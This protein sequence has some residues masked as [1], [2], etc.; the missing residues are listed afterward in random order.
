MTK[1]LTFVALFL[2]GSAPLNYAA[3][4]AKEVI[5]AT[6]GKV[7]FQLAFNQRS[8]ERQIGPSNS[9]N[10]TGARSIAKAALFS[11]VIPG[12]GQIYNGSIL[13]SIFFIA[14]EAGALTGHFINQNRGHELEDV[15]E[16]FADQHWSEQQYWRS[17]AIDAGMDPDNLDL[18]ALRAYEREQFSHFL[19]QQ[20]NQ[21]YYENIGKYDQFNGGW[22]DSISK[23]ARQRDSENRRQYTLKRKDANDH[24][25]R[26][27]NFAAAALLN[28]VFSA[29][30][31]GWS[32]KRHNQKILR[33]DIE[34]QG[35]LYGAEM[36][37]TL[38]LGLSW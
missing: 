17:L 23:M 12:A 30:D 15:F 32:A 38:V 4:T 19:P 6:W 1:S 29:F 31:A 25:K 20:K 35:R 9:P 24:F 5:A 11:A 8:A 37:P 21:T 28:H 22:D 18:D 27:T 3:E 7:D 34:M 2:I 36:I 33:A 26:A 14:V 13:K 10:K 16:A